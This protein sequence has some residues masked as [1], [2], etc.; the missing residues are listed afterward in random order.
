MKG[1]TRF[2][3]NANWDLILTPNQ[4]MNT[5]TR[6]PDRLRGASYTTVTNILNFKEPTFTATIPPEKSGQGV[7]TANVSSGMTRLPIP[8][9]L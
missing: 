2:T 6:K 3:S 7:T 4:S 8:K 5:I 9:W 1:V